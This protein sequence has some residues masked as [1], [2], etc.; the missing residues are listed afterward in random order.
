VSD[1][2]DSGH[3]GDSDID[4]SDITGAMV[5]GVE[6]EKAAKNPP[7]PDPR[8]P[9]PP[10]PIPDHGTHREALVVLL[11]A[12]AIVLAGLWVLGVLR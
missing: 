7:P 3:H 4:V 11:V 9:A 8:A 1:H 2:S 12:S 5:Y 6:I 10:P